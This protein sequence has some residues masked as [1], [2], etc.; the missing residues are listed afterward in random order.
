M[1]AYA[2]LLRYLRPYKGPIAMAVLGM[3]FRSANNTRTNRELIIFVTPRLVENV[4][5]K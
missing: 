3:F 4:A 2:R 5:S 1:S